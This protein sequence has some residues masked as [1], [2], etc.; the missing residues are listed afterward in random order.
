MT[1]QKAAGGKSAGE[2]LAAE[3]WIE[4]ATNILVRQGI[5]AV[6]VE[7]LARKLGVTK[8]SFYWHFKDRDALRLAVLNHWLEQQTSA[9]IRRLN[10]ARLRADERLLQLLHLPEHGA[11]SQRAA[12][13]ELAIRQWAGRDPMAAQMVRQV[14]NY[15]MTFIASLFRELGVS[16]KDSR[17]RAF[18][19]YS[20]MTGRAFF[21]LEDADALLTTAEGWLVAPQRRA[22]TRIK[23]AS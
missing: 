18:A 17:V 6:S 7:P 19:L 22:R 10:D 5:D 9:I 15:R 20:M 12:R 3:H 11:R 8:G 14:D 21:L 16:D 23:R 2:R 13:I 4:A 1:K